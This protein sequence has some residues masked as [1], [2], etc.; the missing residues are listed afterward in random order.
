MSSSLSSIKTILVKPTISYFDKVGNPK[1][2]AMAMAGEEDQLKVLTMWWSPFA[3]CILIALE[4]KGLQ[5]ECQEEQVLSNKTQLL[6]QMNPIYKKVPVLIHNDNPI[7]ESL[8][9]LYYIDESW[10]Q[11]PLLPS[12]PYTRS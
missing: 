10:P 4:E 8:I 1:T 12:D 9:I 2:L 11:N 3:M 7:C 5:Y 6:L